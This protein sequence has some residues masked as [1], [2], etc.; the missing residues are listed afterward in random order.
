VE[1]GAQWR[2]LEQILRPMGFESWERSQWPMHWPKKCCG[3]FL[4]EGKGRRDVVKIQKALRGQKALGKLKFL[5]APCV[6][7]C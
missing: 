1:G 3:Y 4:E 7:S 2:Q 5:G 6:T